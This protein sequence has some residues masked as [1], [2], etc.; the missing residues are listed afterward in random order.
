MFY[1]N[2][3]RHFTSIYNKTIGVFVNN[4]YHADISKFKN[5]LNKTLTCYLS[6]LL[7]NLLNLHLDSTDKMYEDKL[8]ITNIFNEF[9]LSS[10][11]KNTPKILID[12]TEQQKKYN[13]DKEVLIKNLA[14][15]SNKKYFREYECK[16]YI[17]WLI[18]NIKP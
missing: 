11:Y 1:F 2:K 18:S 8:V 5:E 16:K 12:F 10:E 9:L 14:S 6:E 3:Y 15:E 7:K 13:I 4:N 17:S